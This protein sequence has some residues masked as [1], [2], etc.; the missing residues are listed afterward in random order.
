MRENQTSTSMV[1]DK[2]VEVVHYDANRDIKLSK[3][4][5]YLT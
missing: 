5:I 2:I 3:G 1:Q 4:D